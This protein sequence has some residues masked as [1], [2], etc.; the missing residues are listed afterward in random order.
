MI[1]KYEIQRYD[2]SEIFT[3]FYYNF[4]S[5]SGRSS[6]SVNTVCGSPYRW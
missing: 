5:F 6:D 4:V 2:F 3:L 1:F